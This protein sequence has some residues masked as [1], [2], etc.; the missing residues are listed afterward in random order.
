MTATG[1]IKSTVRPEIAAIVFGETSDAAINLELEHYTR[2]DLA[3]V[4]MLEREGVISSAIAKPLLRALCALRRDD[5]EPLR[6]KSIPRGLYLL[7]EGYLIEQLGSSIG[8]WLQI[9]RSRNDLSATVTKLRLRKPCSD[10]LKATAKLTH[11]LCELAMRWSEAVMPAYTHRQPA[12]PITYG[13]YCAGVARA[14]ARDWEGLLLAT[15]ELDTCPLGAC[16]AGG[17]SIPIRP[18]ETARMLG[19]ERP[20]PHSIDAVASRDVVLRLLAALSGL[21]VTLSR[22]AADLLLW[23]TQEFGLLFLPDHVVGSSSAMPQ[24]RNAYLLEHVQGRALAAIG[25]FCTAATLMAK[26]PFS[27]SVCVGNE[28]VKGVWDTLGA[29]RDALTL[30]TEVLVAAE[31][32]G[33]AML[34]SAERGCTGA[35]HCAELLCRAG[36]PFRAAHHRVG[37]LVTESMVLGCPF[38]EFASAALREYDLGPLSA[39][40]AQREAQY[41]G[42]PGEETLRQVVSL[43]HVEAERLTT[44]Q[45]ERER[46]W[47]QSV[48]GLDAEV[49]KSLTQEGTI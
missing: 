33:E 39:T 2:V 38:S 12:V 26:E 4:V 11:S 37:E 49:R 32:Q 36:V 16:A 45:A 14:I 46:R 20:V 10:V 3:H 40:R 41:A 5:F 31:P 7:Y 47:L 27:N 43:L 34:A 13:H 25:A 19:F 48:Q 9:G 15:A 1:R 30:L 28:A 35:T 29:T 24:K 44:S 8:G 18:E 6:G 23:S 22:V 21:G 17:T 42:G